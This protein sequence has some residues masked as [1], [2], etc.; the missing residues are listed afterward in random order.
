MIP[1]KIPEQQIEEILKL[2]EQ[3]QTQEQIAEKL[4]ISRATVSRYLK[5]QKDTLKPKILRRFSMDEINSL[6]D[7]ITPLVIDKLKKEQMT[8]KNEIEWYR[9]KIRNI[10]IS[11]RFSGKKKELIRKYC[12]QKHITMSDLITVAIDNFLKDKN[13]V[14]RS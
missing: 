14:I 6:C 9:K 12:R 10:T 13:N 3:G 11:F 1:D 8:T 5:K 4:G 2:S 7:L